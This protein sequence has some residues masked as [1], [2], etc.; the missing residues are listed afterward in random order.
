MLHEPGEDSGDGGGGSRMQVQ[1]Q[2]GP[3]EAGAGE[4]AVEAPKTG[5]NSFGRGANLQT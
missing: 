5:V 2:E 1:D 3:A 4:I